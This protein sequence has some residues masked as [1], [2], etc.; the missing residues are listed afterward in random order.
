MSSVPPPS[1]RSLLEAMAGGDRDAFAA[2]YDRH[3][4]RVYGLLLCILRDPA[5]AEDLLQEVFL[6]IWEQA[7]RY[8]AARAAPVAW[9]TVIARSRARDRRRRLGR[10]PG[11]GDPIPEFVSPGSIPES[12]A[13]RES[14]ALALAALEA[15]PREQREAIRKSFFDG[16]THGEIARAQN[17]PIGTVKTRIRDGMMKLR[18]QLVTE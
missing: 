10:A 14:A 11:F 17:L 16:M 5:E 6:Q 8:D 4:A 3:A 7:G 15:L 13:E 1:D 2:F 12:L 9:L 18:R